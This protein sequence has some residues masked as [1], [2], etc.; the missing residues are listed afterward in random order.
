MQ[1]GFGS[2]ARRSLLFTGGMA[3]LG[4]AVGGLSAGKAWPAPRFAGNPFSLGVAS[5]EPWPEGV[6]LWT[7]L[8]PQ[9]LAPDG[10]GGMPP[11]KTAVSW[12]VAEDAKFSRVKRR[13]Q[14]WAVP[15]LAHSVHVEVTGLQP[16]RHYF[17]RFRSGGVISPVGRTKTAPA[18]AAK[19][20]QLRFAVTS[21][22][23]WFDGFFTAYRHIANEDFDL[24]FHLGDY[25]YENPIDERG[26]VRGVALDSAVRAEP[27]TLAEYRLRHALHRMDPDLQAAHHAFPWAL[28]WDDHEVEDNYANDV[29]KVDNEP[30]QD[31]AV[32]RQ[33]RA[34]AYQAYYE[35]LPLRLPNRP[36]GPDMRIYRS[37]DYGQLAKFHILDTRQYRDDQACG[38]GQKVDC[39]ER[40]DPSR[41]ILGAD[42]EKWLHRSLERSGATWNVIPQQ[43]IMSQIDVAA[44]PAQK[45]VMDFW[46]GYRATRDRLINKIVQR[47]VRNPVVLT[48]DAHRHLMAELK[49]DFNNPNSRTVGVEFVGTS[50]ATG[51]DGVDLDPS[52]EQILAA[53]PYV[54]FTNFQRGYL[55]CSVDQHQC[56]AD[57][58]ILP[59]VTSPGAPVSTRASFATEN[60]HPGLHRV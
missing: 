30:D 27:F 45:L 35:H 14:V 40:L 42:Q 21:C 4:L 50:I 25:I 22:Q 34:A 46:D 60:G 53:N 11:Q 51:K 7:R 55:R 49:E 18:Q 58:Q 41:T 56:R 19:L 20:A 10:A 38:D 17:Y 15:E 44:G 48:G 5:G 43:V 47:G 39:V 36:F 23:A 3:G 9:P 16:G 31:R 1:G 59:Y 2:M 6:V 52:G 13:G 33:R 24:V 26:G 29:S 28:T 8:A 37:L 54:K 57:L 32:F 12:E